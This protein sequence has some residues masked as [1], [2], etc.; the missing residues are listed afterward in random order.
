M[1]LDW[2]ALAASAPSEPGMWPIDE[3]TVRRDDVDV[4]LC[5]HRPFGGG[6]LQV[7]VDA[8]GDRWIRRVVIDGFALR[9]NC[10]PDALTS[11]EWAQ[12]NF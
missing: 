4:T 2:S 12:L 9:G 3:L 8:S 1:N 11:D 7:I 5:F 10:T 6:D